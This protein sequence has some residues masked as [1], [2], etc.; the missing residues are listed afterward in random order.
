MESI[1]HKE[2]CNDLWQAHSLLERQRQMIDPYQ[3]KAHGKMWDTIVAA[4]SELE[5]YLCP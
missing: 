3:S 1:E 5:D 2:R 4:Q